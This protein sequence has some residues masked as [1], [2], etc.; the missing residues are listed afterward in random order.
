MSAPDLAFDALVS[1]APIVDN[2]T[3]LP[4]RGMAYLEGARCD[5]GSDIPDDQQQCDDCQPCTTCRG[6]GGWQQHDGL[7][8]ECPRGCMTGERGA[9]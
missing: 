1:T 2:A 7:I 3:V 6:N 8:V 9:A 4:M 5:C